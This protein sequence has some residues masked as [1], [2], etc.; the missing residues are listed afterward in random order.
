MKNR[1]IE[2]RIFLSKNT[3]LIVEGALHLQGFY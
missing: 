1:K 2:K 3:G